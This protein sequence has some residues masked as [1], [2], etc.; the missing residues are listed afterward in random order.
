MAIEVEHTENAEQVITNALTK[1]AQMDH[2]IVVYLTCGKTLY[3]SPWLPNAETPF[4]PHCGLKLLEIT[5]DHEIGM[6]DLPS[7]EVVR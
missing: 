4:C 6:A 3:R 1:R 2:G 5:E 7:R